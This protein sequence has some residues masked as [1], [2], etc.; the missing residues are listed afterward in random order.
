MSGARGKVWVVPRAHPDRVR[1]R[2]P[3]RVG[4]EYRKQQGQD[5]LGVRYRGAHGHGMRVSIVQFI[6]GA[7]SIGQETFFRCRA[8]ADYHVMDEGFTWERQDR[9]R[10]TRAAQAAWE[11]ARRLLADPTFALVVIDELN[12]ALK[13][14]YVPLAQ[15]PEALHAR[16]VRQHVVVTGCS[17]PPELI[18]LADMVT[19]MRAVKYTFQAGVRAQKGIEL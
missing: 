6:K 10:D 15:V 14:D 16:P 18:E 2:R 11:Q 19:E 1:D 9:E 13:Y 3:R 17:A 8:E 12:I 7:H 4:G 5:L